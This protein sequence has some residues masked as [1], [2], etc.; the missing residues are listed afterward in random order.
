MTL[1]HFLTEDRLRAKIAYAG[2]HSG[3]LQLHPPESKKD[4]TK[5]QLDNYIYCLPSILS[6][7]NFGDDNGIALIA[8]KLIESARIYKFRGDPTDLNFRELS[9]S[10]DL[11]DMIVDSKNFSK[12]RFRQI[13]L[14]S[15]SAIESWSHSLSRN[16]KDEF[17]E[18]IVDLNNGNFSG[19]DFFMID[20][21]QEEMANF[22][23][24]TSY[25]TKLL[26]PDLRKAG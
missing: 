4:I 25:P 13:L 5:K 9:N 21:K 19:E 26:I 3:K 10:Y 7:M 8:I 20:F 18:A 15:D 6:G 2:S 11:I 17:S 14:L 24:S 23:L 22:C 16:F 1:W 12:I